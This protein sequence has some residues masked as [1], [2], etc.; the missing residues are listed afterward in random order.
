MHCLDRMGSELFHFGYD[1]FYKVALDIICIH[2]FLKVCVGQFVT[3]LVLAVIVGPFLNG[4]VSQVNKSVS[5]VFEVEFSAWRPNV[6]LVVEVGLD[7]SMLS[8]Y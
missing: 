5:C 4:I 8:G 6:S 1:V 3:W 2:V 7:V